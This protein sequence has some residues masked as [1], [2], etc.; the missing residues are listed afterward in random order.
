MS[1]VLLENIPTTELLL[2]SQSLITWRTCEHVRRCD[3]SANYFRFLKLRMKINI[4][5]VWNYCCGDIFVYKKG[6]AAVLSSSAA[7]AWWR[8][9]TSHWS[10]A[11][12]IW[13]GKT[14]R[15]NYTV[16]EIKLVR[17]HLKASN[18]M[19]LRGYVRQIQH[20]ENVCFCCTIFEK[21]K[22]KQ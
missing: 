19:K 14:V 16:R 9:I 1:I 21:D 11:C 18:A 5:E 7:S 12:K 22:M 17:Q 8:Q 10:L 13:Y 2:L 3:T 6:K 4:R 15:T 20:T